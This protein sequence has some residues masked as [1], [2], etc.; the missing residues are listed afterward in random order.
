VSRSEEAVPSCGQQA[1]SLGSELGT[2]TVEATHQGRHILVVCR[3]WQLTDHGRRLSTK[4]TK[5]T[6]ITKT[7]CRPS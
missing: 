1:S 5:L 2:T 4:I 3:H 7:C 6:M